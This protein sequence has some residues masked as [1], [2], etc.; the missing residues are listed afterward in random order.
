MFEIKFKL[1]P[2][3]FSSV[4]LKLDFIFGLLLTN[5]EQIWQQLD[6]FLDP[7]SKFADKFRMTN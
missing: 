2:W 5:M 3:V 1:A 4:H 7:L 6:V